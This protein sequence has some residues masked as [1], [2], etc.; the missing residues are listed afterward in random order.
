MGEMGARSGL[1]FG[2]L[3]L[4]LTVGFMGNNFPLGSLWGFNWSQLSSV[5][6]PIS[7][8]L[9]INVV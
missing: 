5:P 8:D 1:L 7:D 6:L 2:K 9:F 4:V 3:G